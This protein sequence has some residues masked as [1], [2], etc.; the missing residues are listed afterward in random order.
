MSRNV[1]FDENT[2]WRWNDVTK[3]DQN[4]NQFTVE[5]LVTKPG[6]G[7]AQHRALS[8]PPEAARDTPTLTPT[9]TPAT[10]PEPVEFATPHTA[11]STLDVDHDD[12][13]VFRYRR[14]EDLL[15]GGEPS[16]LATCELKEEVAECMP[17]APDEPSS[18]TKVERNP[19]WLK[20]MQEEMTSITEN[21]T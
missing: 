16:G 1:V 17:S 19:C 3:V 6:E 20:A 11:D 21:K 18:F 7:G 13:L 10:P 14:I 4:P 2:F 12:G 5:Y 15:G 8:P 9:T